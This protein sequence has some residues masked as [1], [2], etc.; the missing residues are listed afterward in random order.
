MTKQWFAG[1]DGCRGGWLVVLWDGKEEFRQEVC[2]EFKDVLN[3]TTEPSIIA[4]DM[5]IGLIEEN[6]PNGGRECDQEA[7]QLLGHLMSAVFSPP[8]RMTLWEATDFRS[9]QR[10]NQP[11]GLTIQ[12]FGLFPKL[13]QVDKVMSENPE[14]QKRIKEVHPELC[15]YGAA[16]GRP[17]NYPK[18]SPEGQEERK[19][20]LIELLGNGWHEWYQEVLQRY[21]RSRVAIDDILDASVA[22]WTAERI[23]NGVDGQLKI[24]PADPPEDMKGLRMEMWFYENKELA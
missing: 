9:A 3:I 14:L 20:I 5:P 11:A 23:K 2:S 1:V 12:A 6:P 17:M 15:F 7:R 4:V 22:A 21:T 10:L 8:A 18:R 24:I 19:N 16:G 13:R